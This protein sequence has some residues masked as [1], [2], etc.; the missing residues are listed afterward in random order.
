MDKPNEKKGISRTLKADKFYG[1][2]FDFSDLVARLKKLKALEVNK[3]SWFFNESKNQL[4]LYRPFRTL[5][6]TNKTKNTFTF[7]TK[8]LLSTIVDDELTVKH[9]RQSSQ[10]IESFSLKPIRVKPNSGARRRSLSKRSQ[11][12]LQT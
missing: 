7:P 5:N 12:E 6:S 8:E 2:S 11:F 4:P 3:K 1:P 9:R 10:K